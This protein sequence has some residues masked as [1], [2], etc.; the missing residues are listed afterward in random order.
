M[1]SIVENY[2]AVEKKVSN[3]LLLDIAQASLQSDF[4]SDHP[5]FFVHVNH[6]FIEIHLR[7]DA[8]SN[9]QILRNTAIDTGILIHTIR[10]LMNQLGHE[11]I[12][13]FEMK[14]NDTIRVARISLGVNLTE[15]VQHR[16][17]FA[18]DARY[19]MSQTMNSL[20]KDESIKRE[21]QDIL[22][23]RQLYV[24]Q[25]NVSASQ[26][27]HSQFVILGAYFHLGGWIE[28]G[29]SI[30]KAFEQVNKT[31]AKKIHI[32]CSAK[33]NH[34][35]SEHDRN[36]GRFVLIGFSTQNLE[37]KIQKRHIHDYVL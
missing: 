17:N 23:E 24:Q 31:L 5:L 29:M 14:E 30:G 18:R 16:I 32:C 12:A 36:R 13:D 26:T 35:V 25:S 19:G 3:Q 6:S 10:S 2:K 4:V 8:F 27:N 15:E 7:K 11:S 34:V 20:N 22:I 33:C 28:A 1:L 21:L 9:D 37:Y